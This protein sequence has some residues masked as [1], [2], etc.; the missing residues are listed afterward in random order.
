MN[1]KTFDK[2]YEQLSSEVY[3]SPHMSELLNIMSRQ[4]EEDT[5]VVDRQIITPEE[6]V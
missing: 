1:S 3:Q 5:P 4:L 6:N 2:R